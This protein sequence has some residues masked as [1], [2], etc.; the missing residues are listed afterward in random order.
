[1]VNKNKI[2]INKYG[3]C[4]K[5]YTQGINKGILKIMSK[6][7]ISC[8]SSYRGAQLF[9][10]VGLDQKIVQLC[11]KD[12]ISRVSGS[13]FSDIEVDLTENRDFAWDIGKKVKTGGLLKYVHNEE[14]HDSNPNVVKA[15]QECV[16]PGEYEDYKTYSDLIN[17]RQPSVIRDLLC[18]KTNSKTIP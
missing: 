15:L 14:H 18:L 13:G 6:M 7:G 2:T 10:I 12:T 11:F 16:V 5:N 3:D 4:V 8:V 1:M 17:N 9:E